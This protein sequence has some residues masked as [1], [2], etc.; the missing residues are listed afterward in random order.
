MRSTRNTLYSFAV[1][2][3]FIA[4][5]LMDFSF[6]Q[7][8]PYVKGTEFRTFIGEIIIQIISGV[9]DAFIVGA[10]QVILG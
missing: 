5:P 7:I 1:P 10:A 9:M 3:V 4:T 6:S 2:L 8:G